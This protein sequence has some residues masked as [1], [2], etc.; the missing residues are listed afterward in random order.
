MTRDD[1]RERAALAS[2]ADKYRNMAVLRRAH[3]RGMPE[4]DPSELRALARSF[5]GAL[6]E[7]DR[8]PT[9]EIDER[10]QALRRA[11]LGGT[12]EPWMRWLDGYHA[13][14]RAALHLR[15]LPRGEAVAPEALADLAS[16]HAGIAVDA[17][18]VVRVRGL[19]TG[20]VHLAL[21]HT[22]T[23]FGVTIEQVRA[24]AHPPR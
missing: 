9:S 16:E 19:R 12:I 5:P 7:L 20:L 17:A 23:R 21:E 8:L 18:L 3:G 13:T 10:E 11:S 2:L 6:R 4:A 14:L 24:V 15:A 1:A 22:A